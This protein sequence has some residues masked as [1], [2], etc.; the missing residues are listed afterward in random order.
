MTGA[1]KTRDRLTFHIAN[2]PIVTLPLMTK[3]SG[4]P[5]IYDSNARP[6]IEQRKRGGKGVSDGIDASARWADH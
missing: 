6:L 4:M 3:L 1:G 5:D 2:L